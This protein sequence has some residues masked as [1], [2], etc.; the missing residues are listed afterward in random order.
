MIAVSIVTYH[1]PQ[2][3]L[4]RC[5]QCLHASKV[6]SSV[7]IVD[8]SA[9]NIGYGAG[10]NI[11]IRESKTKYHLVINSDVR[12]EEGTLEYLLDYMEQNP[13]VGQCIPRVEYP[14]GRLQYACRL[15]P[16]PADLF[17]R[18]FLPPT[19]FG[20]SR[21]RYLLADSGYDHEMNVPYH[22]GCFMLFR[23]EALEQIAIVKNNRKEYFDERYFLYPE[24]IDITRRMHSLYRT[25]FVPGVTITHNH[26]AESYHSVRMAFVHIYNMCKYFNKWGWFFDPERRKF[27]EKALGQ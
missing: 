15:L 6:V 20:Q 2:T 4:D 16:T 11:A 24:D 1:T 3:E 17:V 22:M 12:F 21:R 10:H 7:R 19:W 27:N 13:D 5:L 26:R 25:M 8:N 9:K 14:D 18:R 23:R